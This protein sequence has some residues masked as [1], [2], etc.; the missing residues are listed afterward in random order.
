MLPLDA[1]F[2]RRQTDRS[3]TDDRRKSRLLRNHAQ[4]LFT[5]LRESL[6]RD[7]EHAHLALG[8]KNWQRLEDVMLDCPTLVP[9]VLEMAWRMRATAPFQAQFATIIGGPAN[10]KS[11]ALELSGD[12]FD[13]I[14]LSS[15]RGAVR[16]TCL[17]RETEWLSAEQN[18]NAPLV[19]M[20]KQAIG[21]STPPDNAK[22]LKQYSRQGLYEVIKPHLVNVEQ[23]DAVEAYA[24]LSTRAAEL[25]GTRLRCLTSASVVKTF[26]GLDA[27]TGKFAITLADAFADATVEGTP[28][29]KEIVSGHALARLL[30]DGTMLLRNALA[31]RKS[32]LAII[33]KMSVSLGQD[34]WSVLAHTGHL[35]NL[36]HCSGPIAFGFGDVA[37]NIDSAVAKTLANI[38]E[39]K[40]SQ[41][42]A[43][44]LLEI[45]GPECVEAWIRD[46]S[47]I[48]GWRSAVID[49]NKAVPRM[50]AD[51]LNEAEKAAIRPVCE[52]VRDACRPL[53]QPN[54]TTDASQEAVL[55]GSFEPNF[56]LQA[57]AA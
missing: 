34:V 2:D 19:G 15:L 55:D 13:E 20:L 32:A 25:L 14:L 56:P 24:M 37:V 4:S 16:I 10:S 12:S 48:H 47:D 35:K 38:N 29:E 23:F 22:L 54:V 36:V 28:E 49:L 11:E 3:G 53:R 39:D 45:S 40:V 17:R 30:N 43:T 50:A 31:E 46:N 6:A 44:R 7:D 52:Q 51:D 18:K 26:A 42:F 21:L 9:L 1:N 41:Y 5:T 57:A 33:N 27:A 8:L